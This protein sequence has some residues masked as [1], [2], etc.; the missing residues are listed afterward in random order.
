MQT[1][2]TTGVPMRSKKSKLQVVEVWESHISRTVE[3]WTSLK[4]LKDKCEGR[5]IYVVEIPP[6][7]DQEE[8]DHLATA[9][10]A[11]SESAQEA[12]AAV[13]SAADFEGEKLLLNLEIWV[14]LSPTLLVSMEI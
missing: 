3:D 11:E 14:R 4:Y 10:P 13:D 6:E 12:C 1:L 2:D 5:A 8:S 9:T 7:T